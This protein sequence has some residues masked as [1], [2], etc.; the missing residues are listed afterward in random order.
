MSDFE[1]TLHGMT[2]YRKNPTLVPTWRN[3]VFNGHTVPT[4]KTIL[5]AKVGVALLERAEIGIAVSHNSR[6]TFLDDR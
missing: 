1:I 3:S 6:A 5:V 4:C 2:D